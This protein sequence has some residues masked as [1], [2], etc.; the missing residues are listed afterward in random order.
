MNK[1]LRKL[2]IKTFYIEKIIFAEKTYIK[3]GTW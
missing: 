3:K 1:E 2:V